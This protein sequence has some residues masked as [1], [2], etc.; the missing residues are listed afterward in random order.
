MASGKFFRASIT[1]I[2]RPPSPAIL[3]YLNPEPRTP[4]TPE[5]LQ[6][7]KSAFGGFFDV[8]FFLGDDGCD[9][10]QSFALAKIH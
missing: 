8:Y 3:Q 7:L 4:A 1:A 6:L 10:L 5:L 2:R 9:I